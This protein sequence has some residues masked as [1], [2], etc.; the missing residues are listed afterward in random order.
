M[1]DSNHSRFGFDVVG[2]RVV[3]I[4]PD[5]SEPIETAPEPVQR[6]RRQP[7][8]GIDVDRSVLRRLSVERNLEANLF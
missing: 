3:E 8:E 5:P 1:N 7:R 2:D 4:P 6:V